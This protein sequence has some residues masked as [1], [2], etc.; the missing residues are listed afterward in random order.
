MSKIT[1]ELK[2]YGFDP[3]L[4]EIKPEDWQLG[5]IAPVILKEDGN[6]LDFLPTFERQ[7]GNGWDS[8]GCTCYGTTSQIE[9]LQK[10]LEGKEY[11]YAERYP[12]NIVGINPPGANPNDVYQAIRHEGLL[13]Q[14]DLPMTETLG[15]FKEPR[16]MTEELKAKGRLWLNDYELNHEWIASPTHEDIR[17]ALKYSPIALSVTAWF[18]NDKGYAVDNGM[19]NTHWCLAFRAHEDGRIDIFDSYAQDIKTLDPTHK[20]SFAKRIS[21][22]NKK[23]VIQEIEAYKAPSQNWFIQIIHKI[24]TIVSAFWK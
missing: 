20:I 22:L 3:S 5:S 17:F 8:Y 4:V 21:I 16:P 11:N 9:T 10:F 12:Y 2:N 18:F 15:E 23:K 7:Y 14:E 1:G 6:W 13:P 19:G 24:W